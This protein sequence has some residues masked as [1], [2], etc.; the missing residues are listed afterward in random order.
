M[1]NMTNA[2]NEFDALLKG[3]SREEVILNEIF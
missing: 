2:V 3:T 1:D